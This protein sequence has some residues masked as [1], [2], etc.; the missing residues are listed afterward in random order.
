MMQVRPFC[1]D[2]V[3]FAAHLSGLEGWAVSARDYESLVG[4]EPQG[5]FVAQVGGEPAG[6]VLTITYG[7][8][9]WISSLVVRRIYRGHGYGRALLDRAVAYL[10]DRG[11]RTVGLDASPGATELYRDAGF[12]PAFDLLYVRRP[13]LPAPAPTG[14]ALAPLTERDLH[15]VTMFDWACFGASRERVLRSLLQRSPVAFVAQDGPG[16][17]GYLMAR[18]THDHWTIA[19][20]AC[21]RAAEAL[22]TQALAEIGAEPVHLGVP[23]ANVAGVELLQAHGF[24]EY[25]RETRMYQGDPEGI[26]RPELIYAVASSEKG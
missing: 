1:P 4:L 9:G 15:A 12:R 10:L 23:A 8:L 3:A 17:G 22:L 19:P 16:V 18:L 7:K 21:S 26:G 24:A 11:V 13:P 14:A 6:I 20:W 5:C 2:D 25:Y